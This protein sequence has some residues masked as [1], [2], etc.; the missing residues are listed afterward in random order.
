MP[1]RH[2]T[3][4]LLAASLAA[5][6]GRPIVDLD[7]ADGSGSGG[8]TGSAS[9][10]DLTTAPSLPDLPPPET[11]C[12]AQGGR[13]GQTGEPWTLLAGLD[14]HSPAYAL[15][16][17]G[18][19]LLAIWRGE[20]FGTDPMPNFLGARTSFDGQLLSGVASI[21]PTPVLQE[22]AVHRAAE[23]F[24][25]TF[26]GRFGANDELA[27]RILT[28][29]GEPLS[30]EIVR[31]PGTHCGA[32]RPEGVWTGQAYLFA[33]IDNS[34]MQTWLDVGDPVTTAS[35]GAVELTPDGDLS[36]PPRMAVGP[37]RV[38]LVV[39]VRFTGQV[40]AYELAHDGQVLEARSLALPPDYDPGS[41]A[42][43]AHADG[44]FSV[45]LAH[46]DH[47]LYHTRISPGEL[48]QTDPTPVE[49]A[50]AHYDDLLLLHRPG[51]FVMVSYGYELDFAERIHWLVT[52]EAGTVT[53]QGRL[54]TDDDVLYEA[55]PAVAMHEGEAW[56][57]YV[58][59]HEDETYD[60]RLARLGC[61]P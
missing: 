39:G 21:W 35:L 8:S 3:A 61:I 43:G 14:Y 24:L 4:L 54:A 51:G 58:S 1:A 28:A 44:D 22:P 42:V 5:S 41:L 20:F 38:L 55:W 19:G 26:C 48:G 47:G 49:G 46:R 6:C 11:S 33:W 37:E 23:G 59:G 56:V 15:L 52:D 45:Y 36:A 18:G 30:E 40:I 31:L 16:P 7:V 13:F 25:V 60:L 9:A 12:E 32:A 57:L 53:W 2:P 17:S 29:Q 50:T 10:D 27:S 34:T